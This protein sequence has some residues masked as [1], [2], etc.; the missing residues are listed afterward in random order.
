MAT[1]SLPEVFIVMLLRQIS[2][3]VLNS[4]TAVIYNFVIFCKSFVMDKYLVK[5][6]KKSSTHGNSL[7]KE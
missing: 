1:E 6:R 5:A 7:V 4:C 3:K 2:S